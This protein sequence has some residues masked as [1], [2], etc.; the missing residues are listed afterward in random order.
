ME[1]VVYAGLISIKDNKEYMCDANALGRQTT[2]NGHLVVT[3]YDSIPNRLQVPVD[4]CECK[5][6]AVKYRLDAIWDAGSS[7]SAISEET[8]R[9]MGLNISES[10]ISVTASG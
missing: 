2:Y 8:A 4:V 1:N 5:E 9:K 6:G 3:E 10:G 7:M